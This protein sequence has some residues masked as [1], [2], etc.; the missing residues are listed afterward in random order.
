MMKRH[1]IVLCVMATVIAAS[2]IIGCNNETMMNAIPADN[3]AALAGQTKFNNTCANCHSASALAPNA[4]AI[5]NNMGS[6]NSAMN[7]IMLTDEEVTDLMAFLA[8]Q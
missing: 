1:G 5:T 6:V 7:G 2:W 3:T 4:D 8:T